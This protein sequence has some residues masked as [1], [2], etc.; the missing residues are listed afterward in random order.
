MKVNTLKRY[1]RQI[2]LEE[3]GVIGQQKLQSAKVLVIGAGGL[4]CP[5]LQNLAAVGIGT[6]GIIDGDV[7][8]ETNL[9][10]Q[11]LYTL[12]DCGK[13][14]SVIA[15][16]ALK[17]QNSFTKIHTYTV[18]LDETNAYELIEQYDIVVD[19]TDEIKIRYLINDVCLITK[20]SFVY[21]SIHKFQ[22]QL[23]VFNYHNGPSYRCLFPEKENNK[24]LNCEAA[25]VLGVLPNIM[26]TMQAAEVIK[27]ILQIGTVVSGKVLLYDLLL[28]NTTEIEFL[29]NDK[30][31]KI[32]YE[33]GLKLKETKKELL[34]DMNGVEFFQKC[35]TNQYKI[36]DLREIFEKPKLPFQHIESIPINE[37]YKTCH[38]WDKNENIILI[39]QSGIRSSEAKNKL[40]AI[41][42][43]NIGQLKN[44]INSILNLLENEYTES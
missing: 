19:C 27:V 20:K 10:R 28:Q 15:K 1:S 21:A 23:S 33:K 32:G 34:S 42:F 16:K 38:S 24:I 5:V 39:C 7:I 4:G 35:H 17:K 31:I 29:K 25:G 37:L 12:N 13:S 43:R 26:G 18:F 44:G 11:T 30:Q 6:L 40:K 9:H 14:K 2:I 22:G 36:I 41:G 8:D 3:I